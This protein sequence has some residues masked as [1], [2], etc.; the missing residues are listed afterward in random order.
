LKVAS[1]ANAA[2]LHTTE[3]ATN[4]CK[5]QARLQPCSVPPNPSVMTIANQNSN[6]HQLA[7]IGSE[8]EI[9]KQPELAQRWSGTEVCTCGRGRA[10]LSLPYALIFESAA[11]KE[12]FGLDLVVL[13]NDKSY[14][15]PGSAL[16]A[17]M[18]TTSNNSAV[19]N[20]LKSC[21]ERERARE[22]VR[23]P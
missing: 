22:R 14:D 3:K 16:R 12:V 15:Y 7:R 18:G 1:L 10:D 21:L 6:P 2:R 5:L 13:V 19:V 9:R 20:S 4:G 11:A 23:S 17:S 8:S